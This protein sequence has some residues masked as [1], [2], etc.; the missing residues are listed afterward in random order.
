MY[1]LTHETF[2]CHLNFRYYGHNG[3]SYVGF[4]ENMGQIV[5]SF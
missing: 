4:W 5:F 1:L 3:K 2:A